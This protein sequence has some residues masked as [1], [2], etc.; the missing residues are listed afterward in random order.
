[1]GSSTLASLLPPIPLLEALFSLLDEC[2]QKF[3]R[4]F[5]SVCQLPTDTGNLILFRPEGAADQAFHGLRR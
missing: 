4:A 1:M 5:C 2:T 3:M